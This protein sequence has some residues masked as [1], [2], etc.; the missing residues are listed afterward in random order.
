MSWVPPDV[1]VLP[2]SQPRKPGNLATFLEILHGPILALK[3]H[4][5]LTVQPPKV[6]RVML[7]EPPPLGGH[8]FVVVQAGAS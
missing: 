3:E 7:A 5:D 1:G 8:G 4:C 2:H 6:F